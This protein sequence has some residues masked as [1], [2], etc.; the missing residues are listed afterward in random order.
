MVVLDVYGLSA[1]VGVAFFDS[2]FAGG[3]GR[4]EDGRLGRWILLG[5]YCRW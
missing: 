1:G 3:R 2:G 5:F 4:G